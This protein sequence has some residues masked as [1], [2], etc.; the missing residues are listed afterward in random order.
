M[1]KS[2]IKGVSRKVG[3]KTA[4]FEALLG[5]NEWPSGYSNTLGGWR[6][7][8][9]MSL[10]LSCPLSLPQSPHLQNVDSNNHKL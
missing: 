8:L 5:E 10:M 9:L 6:F 1:I 7:G 2:C 4:G 3:L